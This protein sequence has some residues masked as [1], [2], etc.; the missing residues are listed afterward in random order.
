MSQNANDTL[1]F[2]VGDS[3]TFLNRAIRLNPGARVEQVFFSPIGTE[4]FSRSEGA[5]CQWDAGSGEL[6]QRHEFPQATLTAVGFMGSHHSLALIQS[7]NGQHLWDFVAGQEPPAVAPPGGAGVIDA[8]REYFSRF[9]ISADGKLLAG[10]TSGRD[11]SPIIRVWKYEPGKQ[12]HELEETGRFPQVA[13]HLGWMQ[14]TDDGSW[15]MTLGGNEIAQTQPSAAIAMEA[16]IVVHNVTLNQ[17]MN[18][19]CLSS[20]CALSMASMLLI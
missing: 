12:L 11:G 1:T 8:D 5:F 3:V 7:M 4:V 15:L 18:Q 20:C 17:E 14:F 19:F 16:E 10:A 13:K 9:A 6:I 2:G